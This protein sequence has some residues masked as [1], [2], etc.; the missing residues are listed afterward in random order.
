MHQLGRAL[1]RDARAGVDT[2]QWLH[3]TSIKVS[4]HCSYQRTKD[5]YLPLKGNGEKALATE[6]EA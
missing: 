6:I 4:A 5:L 2:T 3:T 1:H